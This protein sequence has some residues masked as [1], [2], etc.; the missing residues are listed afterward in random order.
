MGLVGEVSSVAEVRLGQ[1]RLLRQGLSKIGVFRDHEDRLHAA[2]ARCTH[3]GG[4]VRFNDTER[5]RDC[6][7]HGARFDVGGAVLEHPVT[8]R[9]G[10]LNPTSTHDDDT[11]TR[12]SPR[13]IVGER[14]NRKVMTEKNPDTPAQLSKRTWWGVL[15]RT[16]KEF[17]DD[18]LTDWAAA[19][20]Y[21]AVLSLFPG[22]LLL[23]SLLGLLGPDAT[24]S[25]VDSLNVLG[26]GEAKNLIVGAIENL[27]SSKALAGPLAVIGVVSALW[28]ASG[29]LGAFMRAANSIYDTEEGRPF[30]KVIPL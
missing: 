12:T 23:T 24:K 15:K 25:L 13:R 30:W 7:C 27:Q 14:G 11:S 10:R 6:P 1:G 29:Y 17:N 20:T 5:G 16:V 26:P 3:P 21:Y 4:L 22:L 28:S 19:L 9:P 18:N 2:S 8:A